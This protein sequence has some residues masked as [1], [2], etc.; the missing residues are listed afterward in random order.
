MN[1]KNAILL[2]VFTN[3]ALLLILF[4]TALAAPQDVSIAPTHELSTL[5][6]QEPIPLFTEEIA[7]LQVEPTPVV[8][9]LPPILPVEVVPEVV[10]APPV[11]KDVVVKK[12][13]TLEKIA[14]A[15]K[16]TVDE[17]IKFNHLPSSFLRVGQTLKMPAEKL[18]HEAAPKP[19][20]SASDYYIVKVGDNPWSIA[21]KNHLKVEELLRLNGL[22]EEKA[23]RLK[24][25]DRLRIR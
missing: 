5:P 6:K 14:K 4:L 2:A 25:G 20:E 21:M 17:I 12:G 10:A 9:T 11:T 15:H 3:A 24:A 18:V 22:N 7:T 13:D 23:R 1:R 19:Q 8:H 16:T